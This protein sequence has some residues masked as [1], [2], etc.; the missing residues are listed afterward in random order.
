MI[1]GALGIAGVLATLLL[2]RVWVALALVGAGIFALSLISN[3]PVD[4]ILARSFWTVMTSTEL[5]ALPLFVLMAE[6]LFR[7]NLSRALF[8]G[9]SPWT[10]HLPGRLLH[11]NVIGCTLFA[12]VS[13]SSAATALTV[14][15]ITLKEL[16]ARG[17]A[18]SLAIGSLAGAGTLGF[19]IPP[20]IIMIIY[21]VLAEVSILKLFIA[22]IAPGLALAFLYTAYIAVRAGLNPALAPATDE[23]V[24]WRMRLVALTELLPIALLIFAIIG[25]LYAG[26]ASPTEAAAV[27]VFA[28]LALA[29]GQRQLSRQGLQEALFSAV[30]I[31]SMAGLIVTAGSFFAISLAYLGAPQE[32]ADAVAA[33]EL[34]GAQLIVVLLIVYIALGLFL[35]GMST[36]IMTLPITLPLVLAAGYDPIWFGI[37]IVLTIE[38]AQITPPV[39]FNLFVIESLTKEPLGRIAAYAF[40][41]FII[42]LALTL[43]ITVFPDLVLFAVR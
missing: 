23:S 11:V 6:I 13:G 3:L 5:L 16:E 28:A 19:L 22:G 29:A 21:G 31:S 38:M 43:A 34:S 42:T 37:F 36:V 25:S 27:G 4:R 30:R 32:V 18:K 1:A 15:R 9:L 33:A 12:A 20:S 17:Y 26:L 2:V 24:S 7:T 35:D 41:F 40:P 14:G 10:S 8:R 39:G